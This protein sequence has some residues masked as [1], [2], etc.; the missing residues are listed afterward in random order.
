[1][2]FTSQHLPNLNLPRLTLLAFFDLLG[3]CLPYIER[4]SPCLL[5]RH[6]VNGHLLFPFS[7]ISAFAEIQ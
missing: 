3:L 5:K 7:H 6:N 1:M 2:N 4:M